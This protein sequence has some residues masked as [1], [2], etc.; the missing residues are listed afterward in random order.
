MEN[1]EPQ[2]MNVEESAQGALSESENI[3]IIEKYNPLKDPNFWIVFVLVGIASIVYLFSIGIHTVSVTTLMLFL[4]WE[5]WI[6][7]KKGKKGSLLIGFLIGILV[8][9][10]TMFIGIQIEN[11]VRPSINDRLEERFEESMQ[12]TLE[13]I[14]EEEEEEYSDS[15]KNILNEDVDTKKYTNEKYG[16]SLDYYDNFTPFTEISDEWGVVI[17]PTP[18][19]ENV[20]FTIDVP[21]LFC[22]EPISTSIRAVDGILEFPKWRNHLEVSDEHYEIFNYQEKIVDFKG[23]NAYEVT[24]EGRGH[25]VV[26]RSKILMTHHNGNTL[27]IRQPFDSPEYKNWFFITD[28]IEFN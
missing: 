11:A 8:A 3:D 7:F 10:A 13:R 26:G 19:S 4:T 23:K 22:C 16:Y 20:S 17:S 27:F 2:N 15:T 1:Q 5:G 28:S 25:T 18:T 12:E 24:W 14:L 6:I 21:K 9:A